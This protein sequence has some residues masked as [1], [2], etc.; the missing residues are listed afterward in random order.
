[1]LALSLV[2]TALAKADESTDRAAELFK[3]GR[4]LI[5]D[6]NVAD[7]CTAFAR[8][9]ELDPQL[10]TKLNVADC[11]AKLGR[12]ADAYRMFEDAEKD[13]ART[14]KRGR[15][16]YA[17]EQLTALRAK[18]GFVRVRVAEPS[19]PG[20]V[21]E[22]GPPNSARQLAPEALAQ[23][24]IF[25]PGIIVLTA[26]AAQRES[27]R[28]EKTLAAGD[29]ITIDVPA[30]PAAKRAPPS[31]VVEL[32]RSRTPLW[33]SGGVGVALFGGSAV[34]G[35]IARSSY[36]RA[37]QAQDRDAVHRAAVLADVGTGVAIAGGVA[38][39]AGLVWYFVAPARPVMVAPA[40]TAS[41][42]ELIIEGRF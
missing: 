15:A 32:R 9:L 37:V 40:V 34:V 1:V 16:T 17:R 7:A 13:A 30:L 19:L 2:T 39:A 11:W 24:Q 21:I 5:A 4:A 33:I 41:G 36:Q 12:Y 14:D 20:L 42:T 27:I 26:R 25:D 3:Q 29:E 23:V 28:V 10:G 38:F 22:I 31:E 8:S 35:L 6:G 18:V